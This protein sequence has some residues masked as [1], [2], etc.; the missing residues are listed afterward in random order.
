[1]SKAEWDLCSFWQLERLQ[2]NGPTEQQPARSAA[3]ATAAPNLRVCI[4]FPQVCLQPPW[5]RPLTSWR[6]VCR[7]QP[8]P[9]RPLTQELL[10]ASGRY[11]ERKA[12]ELCGRELEVCFV[13]QNAH[14]VHKVVG[15]HKPLWTLLFP[16]LPAR[17]CRSSPQ[18]G[19]TLVT[20]ELLQRW[21]YVDFGGQYVDFWNYLNFFPLGTKWTQYLV[22]FVLQAV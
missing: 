11:W 8:G 12:S 10:T 15:T 16:L 7:S 1:M 18:F 9:D 3:R 14:C 13:A 20:Y 4:F 22:F 5:W 21:F 17:M 19:V 6:R 2:V